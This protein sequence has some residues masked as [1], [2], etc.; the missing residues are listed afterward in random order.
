[1]LLNSHTLENL[2]VET[3]SGTYLGRVQSFDFDVDSQAMRTYHIKP[4]ILEGG[5]FKEELVVHHKQVVSITKE[6]MVVL[7]N[8]VKYGEEKKVPVGNVKAEA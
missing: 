1:M 6:K 8:V 3:E 4:K 5:T 7:D 2:R